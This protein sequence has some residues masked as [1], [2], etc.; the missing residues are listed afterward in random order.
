MP[1]DDYA[2]L[3]DQVWEYKRDSSD[4]SKKAYQTTGFKFYDPTM[5]QTIPM[6]KRMAYT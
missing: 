5:D 1:T 4:I 6:Y 3:D 2:S